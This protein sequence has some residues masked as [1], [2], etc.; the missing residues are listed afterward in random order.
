[1]KIVFI[2]G[3]GDGAR[4]EDEALVRS[5]REAL[6]ELETLY[7]ELP[8]EDEPQYD[9]WAKRIRAE[10]PAIV[11]AHSIGASIAA[12]CLI[13]SDALALF[14]IANPFWGGAGWRYEGWQELA[15]PAEAAFDVPVFLY[16]ARDDEIVPFE[17]LAL[18][19]AALP[20]AVVREI[21]G[22]GHQ[23][24]GDLSAV[25]DDIRSLSVAG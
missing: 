24:E 21:E 16:H 20:A 15:M 13:G 10:L 2:H 4:A 8:D 6:P 25:A 9:A 3:A 11:V 22:G 5:L 1:M 19:S 18:W 17:H 23:L 12:K 7:P 14:L